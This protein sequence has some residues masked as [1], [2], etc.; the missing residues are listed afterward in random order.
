M[1]NLLKKEAGARPHTSNPGLPTKASSEMRVIDTHRIENITSVDE[2]IYRLG[3]F[4]H[5][6]L[7]FTQV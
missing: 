4:I 6:T 2:N 7:M 3:C 5:A 1:R